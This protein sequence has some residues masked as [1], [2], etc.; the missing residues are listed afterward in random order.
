MHTLDY[1][2]KDSQRAE[3]IIDILKTLPEEKFDINYI[4]IMYR[5]LILLV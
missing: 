1:A 2:L 3:E 4:K 5:I